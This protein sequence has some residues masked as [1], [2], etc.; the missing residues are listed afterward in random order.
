M[1]FD[2][3]QNFFELS[4]DKGGVSYGL[5]LARLGVLVYLA[6]LAFP[7]TAALRNIALLSM[8]ISIPMLYRQ[9]HL[10]FD[11][12]SPLW[13]ILA[14]LLSVLAIS[15]ML[16]SD[17]ADSFGELRKHF[18]PGVLLL[19]LL[20]SVFASDRQIRILLLIIGASFSLR[21]ALTLAELAVFLPDLDAG[22]ANGRFIKG[23]ALDA[24]FYIPVLFGVLFLQ[25]K[26]RWLTWLGLPLVIGCMV[27]V[28]SRTPILAGLLAVAC[29]LLLLRR[30]KSLLFAVLSVLMIAVYVALAQPQISERLASSF[31]VETYRTAFDLQNFKTPK[32]GLTERVAIWSGVVE[33]TEARLLLGYGFGWKKLGLTAESAGFLAAW[34]AKEGDALAETK[35]RYFSQPTSKVNPHSLY[36]QIYFE[37]GLLGLL[38]YSAFLV[39]LFWQAVRLTTAAPDRTSLIGGA[40]V[41]AYLVDHVILGLGNGL[42]FGLGPSFAFLGLLEIL[43][44]R[45]IKP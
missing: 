1:M 35:V 34:R 10:V 32:D 17:P 18:L 16:G 6:A 14:L 41:F 2:R 25:G 31:N 38:M 12:R 4:D 8:L 30:W 19:V 44:H 33:I 42:W 22:R 40:I 37:S 7:H 11:W 15:A 20:P 3:L 5:L 45:P 26:M 9:R 36:L 27:F 24:G 13:R 29:M 43:R 28:Q 39:T 21:A 23:F